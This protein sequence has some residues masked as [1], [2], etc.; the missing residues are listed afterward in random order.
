MT[1]P[2]QANGA[3]PAEPKSELRVQAEDGKS[4]ERQLADMALSPIA[5]G[6]ATARAFTKPS[7][8]EQSVEGLF[9]S[10]AD[11]VVAAKGGDLGTQKA[12]LACQAVALNTIFTELA[13]RAAANMGEYIDATERYMRLALKAQAQSRATVEALERLTGGREQT[14]R[15]V[16]VDNRGGQ[17]VIAETVQT[18]SKENGQSNEQPL[19]IES[20]APASGQPLWSENAQREAVPVARH[21]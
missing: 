18:G 8:G 15:H 16:H 4:K 1:K 20:G 9:E 21:A 10:L 14:V 3:K 5:H 11:H 19:A 7:F 6:M 12:M 17:A 13:R 2:K